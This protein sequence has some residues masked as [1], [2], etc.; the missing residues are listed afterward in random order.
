M[1]NSD[2]EPAFLQIDR[3]LSGARWQ[4]RNVDER[5]V[6][7]VNQR[8]GYPDILARVLSARGV[9]LEEI[10]AHLDPKIRQYMPD[11]SVLKN[12]DQ[13]VERLIAAIKGNEKIT[14]FGDYDVDGATST[15]LLIR[16]LNCLN[17]AADFYIPDRMVEGYGPNPAAFDKI[18][19]QGARLVVTVDC[20]TM[21]HDA[22]AHA[23]DIGL[24]V[25]VI[26]HHQT[27]ATPPECVA[28]V[29]PRQIGDESGLGHLAAVGVV[30]MVIVGLN[31]ALREEGY[32]ATSQPVDLISFLDLVALGTVCDVVPLQGLNRAFVTQGLAVMNHG[33]RA[34]LK[35]LA[36]VARAQQP[37]GTYDLGFVM[38]PRVNAGGRVGASELGTRL[39]INDNVEETA[40]LAMRL[41]DYNRE[42]RD[43]EA[44]VLAQAKAQI[45]TQIAGLNRVPSALIVSSNE[46]HAGVIGI[47]AS[48]LKD[49][50]NRPSFV[51]SFDEA[52][53]GKGSARSVP[54]FDLGQVI[55]R[56]QADGLIE[57]GGG[58]AMAAGMSVRRDQMPAF[59]A[60]LLSLL[61]D[62]DLSDRRP[63]SV[64]A[65]LSPNAATRELWEMLERA[66]PFGAANPEPVFVLPSVRVG[67]SKTVGEGHVQCA[68][69]DD[70]GGRLKGIAFSSVDEHVRGALLTYRGPMHIAGYMRA[71]DW[72]GRRNVQFLVKDAAISQ[73]S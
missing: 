57:S 47:V 61:D 2:Q 65:L 45:E 71:D 8:Y 44:L 72:Q 36:Q 25:I 62:A 41:D 53:M 35:A 14:I 6:Q 34:G 22:L 18:K 64:D 32:F 17:V 31:R 70:Q 29:N 68:F 4:G 48:R 30:F 33:H 37:Y 27:A 55:T 10:E 50:Y 63:I 21:A 52:G 3:S 49:Q 59:E 23:R 43:I 60:H 19:E 67:F 46:W 11:P 24:D 13:A 40:A 28:L 15:S 9:S 39:L 26:D 69:T 51:I 16:Y 42:R 7:A 1:T 38:G 58:H 5:F 54:G 66:G 56:M 12:C 73:G 20:G